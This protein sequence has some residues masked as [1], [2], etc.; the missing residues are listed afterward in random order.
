MLEIQGVMLTSVNQALDIVAE[1]VPDTD[2]QIVIERR[3]Q[4]MVIP[5]RIGTRLDTE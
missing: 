1:S 2:V 3:G 4:R 5:T